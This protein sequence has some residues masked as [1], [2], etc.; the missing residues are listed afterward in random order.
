MPENNKKWSRKYEKCIKCGKTEKRHLGRGLCSKCYQIDIDSKHKGQ[1]LS[2]GMA[3]NLF[4]KEYLIQKYH[5][6]EK[7][8]SDIA[9]SGGCTRSFVSKKMKEYGILTRDLSQARILALKQKKIYYDHIDDSTGIFKRITHEKKNVNE[10]FFSEWSTKMA[11]VLGVIYTDGWIYIKERNYIIS[12]G[13]KE[14]ELLDKIKDLMDCNAKLSF[15]P[16]KDYNG[17]VSGELYILSLF[18]RKIVEDLLKLGVTQRKSLTIK[19]PTMPTKYVRHFIRGCWDGD[20]GIWFDKHSNNYATSFTSGSKDFIYSIEKELHEAGLPKRKIYSKNNSYKFKY[21]GNQIS[22]LYSYLYNQVS[23]KMYL[24][25]KY[26][27]FRKTYYLNKDTFFTRTRESHRFLKSFRGPENTTEKK[28]ITYFG[29]DSNNTSMYTIIV[30][31]ANF[32][33]Q[34]ENKLILYELNEL[35]FQVYCKMIHKIEATFTGV[36]HEVLQKY[37]KLFFAGWK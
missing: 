3:S 26:D 28:I 5:S 35:G 18:S 2:K 19:F 31:A 12:I 20:G 34:E 37:E 4:T 22:I 29:K 25:N 36:F 11:Y 30:R 21:T 9:W 14:P 33:N 27:L 32:D 13:Q 23:S 7:S 15:S 8:L 17:V 10:D 24:S 6:E 1:Q 16:K